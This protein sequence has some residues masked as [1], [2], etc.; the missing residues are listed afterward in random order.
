MG[1]AALGWRGEIV[2]RERE[3]ERGI[4][5][6]SGGVISILHGFIFRTPKSL[7]RDSINQIAHLFI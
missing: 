3:R 2:R 6:K 1:G 7:I 4:L 5:I